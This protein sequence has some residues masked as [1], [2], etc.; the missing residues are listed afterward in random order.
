G[1]VVW[2]DAP[3]EL[4]LKRLQHDPTPRPLLRAADSAARFATL[5]E[6]RLPLYAQAD[7]RIAQSGEPPEAVA[8][9]VLEQLPAILKQTERPP[10]EPARLVGNDGQERTSLN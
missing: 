6:Q 7:L 1:V 8:A 5:L 10:R 4:L 9:T 3:A 2:L